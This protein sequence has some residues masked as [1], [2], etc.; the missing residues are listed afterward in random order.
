M[1]EITAAMVKEL[2]E[3]TGRADDGMQEGAGRGR[4]RP[5]EGRGAA[6]RQAAATRRAR[7]RRASRPKAW[8]AVHIAGR[9]ARRD[10]R[11]QLRNRLR[12][13][14]RRLPGVRQGPRGAGREEQ[15]GRRCRAVC[16]PARRRHGRN[17]RT[18]LVGKIGE[19]IS[20]RR[21]ARL[22][23]AGQAGAAMCTAAARSACWST[24]SGADD[25]LAKDVAMHIAAQQAEVSGCQRRC[26][27]AARCRARASRSRRRARPASRKRCWRRWSEGSR[28]EVPEGSDAA[29][30]AVRQGREASRRSSS[31]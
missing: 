23:G 6:A 20:I 9:E 19:N 7:R 4:R 3:K 24:S 13:Q 22:R 29:G 28:A 31:C 15:S 26:G 5:E 25:E 18:A 2:R 17:R 21:F 11:G 30:P 1:A 8:S 14:E 12:R 16:A 10:G 27:R